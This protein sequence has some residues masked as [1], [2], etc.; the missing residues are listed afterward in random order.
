MPIHAATRTST[1]DPYK[2]FGDS[3]LGGKGRYCVTP[4]GKRRSVVLRAWNAVKRQ[5]EHVANVLAPS[6]T[7]AKPQFREALR[8]CSHQVGNVFR[9][10]SQPGLPSQ[11]AVDQCINACIKA[12]QSVAALPGAGATTAQAVI[13][14]RLEVH[15][16]AMNMQQ[17]LALKTG[18]DKVMANAVEG[19]DDIANFLSTLA[20]AVHQQLKARATQAAQHLLKA[21][22]HPNARMREPQVLQVCV[23]RFEAAMAALPPDRRKSLIEVL[24]ERLPEMSTRSLGTLCHR[25]QPGIDSSIRPDTQVAPSGADL[26]P[27]ARALIQ[28]VFTAE[29]PFWLA[30][31]TPV[32]AQQA[33][34]AIARQE[35]QDQAAQ[36]VQLHA[37]TS[38]KI[39]VKMSHQ[40]VRELRSAEFRVARAD[41]QPDRLLDP[42]TLASQGTGEYLEQMEQACA[43]LLALTGGDQNWLYHVSRFCHQGLVSFASKALASEHSPVSLDG[44]RGPLLKGEGSHELTSY[45]LRREGEKI[46]IRAEYTIT[47]PEYLMDAESANPHELNPER[48]GARFAIEVDVDREGSIEL[49]APVTVVSALRRKDA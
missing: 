27:L 39:P 13:K 14:A 42:K 34:Q 47:Q 7:R 29:T 1:P 44:L 12:S 5:G 16:N 4:N 26:L 23:D 33:V 40:F 20:N 37:L 9:V 35:L 2:Q 6:G 8:I 30:L 24:E 41:G 31:G 49:R 45:Q 15:L 22:T 18:L 43:K 3:P 46:V 17:L 25:L 32:Q 48:S 10:V 36:E 28:G 38:Q 11:D 19:G 21:M